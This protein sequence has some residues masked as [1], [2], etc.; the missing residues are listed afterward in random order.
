MYLKVI[1]QEPE[2]SSSYYMLALLYNETGNTKKALEFSHKACEKETVS[3]SVFYNYALLLQKEKHF[4]ES[5]LAID[6]GLVLFPN[7]EK[8]LYVKLLGQLN[9][10]LTKEASATCLKLIEIAP[11]N[12]NY[13]Q[14]LKNIDSN[15]R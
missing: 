4:K 3:S 10:K 8:L 5:I 9:L 11:N 14:I 2:F 13:K 15:Y 12:L 7:S 6:K 1:E